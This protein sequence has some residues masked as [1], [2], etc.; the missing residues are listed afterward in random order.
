MAGRQVVRLNDGG[1]QQGF[2]GVFFWHSGTGVARL[3]FVP[4][5]A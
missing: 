5:G 3:R 2:S 1:S 4:S